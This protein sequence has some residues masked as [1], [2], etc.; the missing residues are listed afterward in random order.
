MHETRN[1]VLVLLLVAAAIW[2]G[3][4]WVFGPDDQTSLWAQR[5]AASIVL[6]ALAAWLLYALK[7]EDKLPDHLSGVVGD[8]YY[9]AEGLDFMPTV[10]HAQGQAELCLYYQ[11]RYENPA[12]VIVHLR[13]PDDSFIIRP[14]VR[15]VHFAFKAGGGDFGAIHQ[16]IAIP[17]HLQGEV[18]EVRLAAA[19]YYPRSQG[20]RLRRRG[21]LPSGSLYVDWAGAAF[22]TGVH[23]VSGEIELKSPVT[24]HLSMPKGVNAFATGSESWHQECMAPGK[25]T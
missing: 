23:E 3:I 6:L 13:P 2:C 8:I 1:F 7:F 25:T 9:G 21:G 15:D 5:V 20:A 18:I 24:L 22:K 17:E 16:P 12:E 14:G 10:R 11:N 19:S 4:A